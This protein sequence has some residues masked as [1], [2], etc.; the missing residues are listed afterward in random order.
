MADGTI[1]LPEIAA[2]S[3]PTPATG[4]Q[5]IFIDSA[6]KLVKV[7]D[8]TGTVKTLTGITSIGAD[9]GGSTTG[10]AVTITAGTGIS[11]T[12]SGTSITIAATGVAQARYVIQGTVVNV[13]GNATTSIFPSS[14]D[15]L[16]NYAGSVVAI[17]IISNAARTA[18]TCQ[19]RVRKNGVAQTGVGQTV[20]L[21]G[22]NTTSIR[23]TLTT[24]VTFA[25]G[26]TIGAETLTTSFTPTGADVTVLLWVVE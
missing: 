12:R 1:R 9:T 20:T 4:K 11:T 7:K 10:P 17:S 2:A 13:G 26:D 22:T 18:G 6:D 21:D 16:M 25:A 23:L 19:L 15:P 24:P 8:D 3:V 14:P 5:F